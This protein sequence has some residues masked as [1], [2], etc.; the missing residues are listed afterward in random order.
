MGKPEYPE[1]YVYRKLFSAIERVIRMRE[2]RVYVSF[3]KPIF[4]LGFKQ[5]L[6]GQLTSEFEEIAR[7]FIY[8]TA[9]EFKI[10]QDVVLPDDIVQKKWQFPIVLHEPDDSVLQEVYQ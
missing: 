1:S 10:D 2:E 9:R 8:E 7:Q 6:D 4:E 5:F 3:A